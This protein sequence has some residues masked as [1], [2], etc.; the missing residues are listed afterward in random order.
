VDLFKNWI[1]V[2]GISDDG[3]P[4]KSDVG[5]TSASTSAWIV[6][7]ITH[8]SGVS[9]RISFT[10]DPCKKLNKV[11]RT[12]VRKIMGGKLQIKVINCIGKY[13]VSQVNSNLDL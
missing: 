6:I 8:S 7:L 3:R 4:I 1:D 2:T 10:T 9:F 12:V 11:R 13:G 5:N